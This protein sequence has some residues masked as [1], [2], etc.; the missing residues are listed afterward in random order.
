MKYKFKVDC[1]LFYGRYGLVASLYFYKFPY[2]RQTFTK[3]LITMLENIDITN[4]LFLD[5]ETVSN[6]KDYDSQSEIFQKL[7]RSMTC[8]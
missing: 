3:S 7:W 1:F 2:I 5:I 6:Q 4:V 8:S